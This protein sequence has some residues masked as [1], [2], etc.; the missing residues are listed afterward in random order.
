MAT[1]PPGRVDGKHFASSKG[2]LTLD[3]HDRDPFD[4]RSHES[5]YRGALLF[6]SSD[7]TTDPVALNWDCGGSPGLR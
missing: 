6:I 3:I 5:A 2:R 4:K 7:N 1:R